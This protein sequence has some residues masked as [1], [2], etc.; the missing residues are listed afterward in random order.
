MKTLLIDGDN[1]FNLGFFGVR[2]FFVDGTHIGGLYHFIDAI[3]KQLDEHDYDKVFVVWDDEHNS[4]RRREIYPYYKLNRRER[5]NE[6]QRESFNIQKNKVQNYLEEFFIRQLKVP[7]NEGDDL[8]SYYCLHAVKETITIFSSDKDLLQLLNS[9]ISVY[10][11]LHKKYFYEGDK[12]KLDEIEVPHVNLLLA[13]I[14]LGDK[15]DNVFGILNFGEKTL[16]KFFPEVLEHPTTLEHILS[17]TKEIYQTKK[18]KGLENLM[19]GRCKNSE[20]GLEFFNKRRMIMD[21]HNP[22]ITENA[23]ELVLEN[24]RDNIDPEGRSY[25][26][27]I[28]MMTQDGFFKYLP[29]TDEGFVE[30]LRPFMKLTRKEKRKFNREEKS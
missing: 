29:K 10:S 6:F 1:L 14:L 21:L 19:S 3:R 7:Y 28:R 30:F 27:V 18:L 25:K 4:S 13:K 26:N 16:V 2:D 20:E 17:K 12:I 9:R 15:S 23:K 8:I 22:M 5:L 11:P 24:I